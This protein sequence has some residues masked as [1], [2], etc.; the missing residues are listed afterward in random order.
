MK[1]LSIA[2]LFFFFLRFIYSFTGCGGVF[3]VT[4]GL[5]PVVVHGLLIAMASPVADYRL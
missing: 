5:S 3:V 2:F 4:H 1:E